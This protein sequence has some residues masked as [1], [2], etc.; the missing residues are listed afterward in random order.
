MS[1]TVL[2]LVAKAAKHSPLTGCDLSEGYNQLVKNALGLDSLTSPFKFKL[3]F[4][5]KIESLIIDHEC[6]SFFDI[7]ML[8]VATWH[9]VIHER[10]KPF[11]FN[12]LKKVLAQ[13]DFIIEL[14]NDEMTRCEVEAAADTAFDFFSIEESLQKMTTKGFDFQ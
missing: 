2:K 3:D 9:I 11:N 12:T 4:F 13:Y 14:N 1:L 10:F 5:G 6:I 8:I 7:Q